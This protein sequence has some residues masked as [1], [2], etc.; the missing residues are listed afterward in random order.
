MAPVRGKVTYQGKPIPFGTV[1]FQHESGGQPASGEIKDGAYELNTFSL[2]A[3]ARAGK[4]LVRITSFEGQN[5]AKRKTL[6]SGEV[7]LGKSLIPEKYQ[8][9]GNGLTAD[10]KPDEE[11]T[12]DFNLTK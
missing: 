7:V 5:P 9:F 6:G 12:F 4:N 1:M 3:G 2:G 11:Q 8:T 10:V